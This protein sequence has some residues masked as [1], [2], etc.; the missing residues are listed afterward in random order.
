[1]SRLIVGDAV[2]LFPEHAGRDVDVTDFGGVTHPAR[3]WPAVVI[4]LGGLLAEIA[5]QRWEDAGKI[6]MLSRGDSA[7][8]YDRLMHGERLGIKV[9]DD[10]TEFVE[11]DLLR[12]DPAKKWGGA[13]MATPDELDA[14]LGASAEALLVEAGGLA[15][16][17]R[18]E[19]LGDTSKRRNRLCATFPAGEPVGPLAVYVLTRIL[20][21]LATEVA[22]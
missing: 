7:P 15:F 2:L 4:G 17:K 1:M 20:P 5:Y 10:G 8:S 16:G 21:I 9:L 22:S 14:T 11:A 3:E 12:W 13:T 18:S 19:V 6:V